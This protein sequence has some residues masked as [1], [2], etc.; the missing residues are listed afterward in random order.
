MLL[1]GEGAP[2]KTHS[3]P[4]HATPK[5]MNESRPAVRPS[6]NVTAK[7]PIFFRALIISAG[8]RSF[9]LL[10]SCVNESMA[11]VPMSSSAPMVQPQQ[12]HGSSAVGN[13]GGGSF[14][15]FF[16][17][18]GR[19][20]EVL[21]QLHGRLVSAHQLSLPMA[22]QPPVSTGITSTSSSQQVR[23]SS[24]YIVMYRGIPLC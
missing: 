19:V 4:S 2:D 18:E 21:Q 1:Q 3:Q 11:G 24:V 6:N 10:P 8:K 5:T 9:Y 12:T 22:Q 17:E 13:F 20:R 15:K 7:M 16:T 14:S 23:S